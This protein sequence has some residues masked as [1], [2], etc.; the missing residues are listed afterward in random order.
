MPLENLKLAPKKTVGTKQTLK[1]VEKGM[2]R[3]VF[4]ASDAEP[5]VTRSL[6][7]SCES[8]GIPVVEVDTMAEL[9]KACGIDVGS[10]S[11]AIL[12]D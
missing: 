1:A 11:A 7:Q 9:G 2:A 10:A 12:K 6:L 4:I 8:Q 5:R 3:M